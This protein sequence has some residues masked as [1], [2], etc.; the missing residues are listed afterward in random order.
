MG[1]S[2]TT[3]A[4][5]AE[6]E[7]GGELGGEDLRAMGFEY[8]V[9][10]RDGKVF[11]GETRRDA[12]GRPVAGVEAE[13]AYAVGSGSQGLSYLIERDGR[14]FQSPISWYSKAGKWDLSPGFERHNLP[15]RAAG[16]A[17][18]PVL[19]RQ[20]G[21]AGA[22]DD[23][24]LPAT[25]LPGARDRLRAVPRAR[26]TARPDPGHGD[27]RRRRYDRQPATAGSRRCAT[28]SASSA[29]SR[30]GSG[31]SRSARGPRTTAP[32][33]RWM[34]FL[35]VFVDPEQAA[36]KGR[37]VG[38]VEQLHA[39]RC[40]RESRGRLGCI[41]C[42]DPH[43]LPDPEERVAYFRDRCLDCHSEGRGC[44][45]PKRGGGSGAARTVASNATC[46]AHPWPTSS[47]PPRPTIASRGS[48]VRT[49]RRQPRPS[50]RT[51]SRRHSSRSPADVRPT[52]RRPTST[53]T[54][55]SP[56]ARRA[57]TVR[58]PLGTRLVLRSLPLLESALR[59]TGRTMWPPG[60]PSGS[61]W[62]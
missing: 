62:R 47:T 34:R 41:S 58:G 49:T 43:R 3:A 24:C 28:R 38:H 12:A 31:S 15:L 2:L 32:G 5:A 30:A 20:P 16:R 23:Q 51:E 60:K 22:G 54:S 52:R 29:T 46:R 1:R 61:P 45:L 57:R 26:R 39:S 17:G 44:S 50:A 55:V 56:S 48:R 10:R 13:V 19:P 35:R 36:G 11:H 14:L 59:V 27:R 53:A 18:V 40:F 33:C 8:S 25:D 9:A 21:R 6:R 7:A 42:H 37:S 4:E